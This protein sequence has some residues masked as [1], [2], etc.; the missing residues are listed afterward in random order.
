MAALQP[1]LRKTRF[2]CV[3]D[4]HNAIP[5]GA[6]KLP[7]GDV[8][9][10]AGDMTNQGS[11]SELRK[12]LNWLEEA[13]FETKVII[14]GEPPAP[15]TNHL[16]D[17]PGNHDITLDSDF[18]ALHGSTFHNQIPE[19]PSKCQQLLENSPSILW[20]KHGSAVVNLQSPTGPRTTFKIFGSPYSPAWGTWA[21][22]YGAD[23]ATNIWDGIPDDADIVMTHTPPMHHRDGAN[24]HKPVGCPALR[25]ALQR[26]QPQL[27]VCGHIHSARGVEFVRWNATASDA[28]YERW[29]IE[30]WKD[31]GKGNKRVS[32]VD[33]TTRQNNSA[34]DADLICHD[35]E[36]DPHSSTIPGPV[37]VPESLRRLDSKAKYKVIPNPIPSSATQ[38]Q[39]DISNR[40]LGCHETCIVN[41]AI[42][43]SGWPHPG[44]KKYNKPI[45]VE[46]DLPTWEK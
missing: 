5:G 31:P 19:D 9:L 7:K 42:M 26:I 33:L 8:L 14:A 15:S 18:Y 21:F 22:A 12:T 23:E 36:T 29:S 35:D 20:L 17:R 25:E 34:H 2:V 38:H 39:G 6:F 32:L 11:Y 24:D 41:A 16:A 10:H 13:D 45:V 28:K 43:A 3:S 46:I 40:G 1:T 27:V 30:K 44:G 37:D 4:T